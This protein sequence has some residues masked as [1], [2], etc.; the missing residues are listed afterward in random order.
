MT[1]TATDTKIAKSMAMLTI[2]NTATATI[3]TIA[4]ETSKADVTVFSTATT[5][6][7][8]IPMAPDEPMARAEMTLNTNMTVRRKV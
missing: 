3:K 1:A 2:V 7:M 5:N 8:A 6:T 4:T